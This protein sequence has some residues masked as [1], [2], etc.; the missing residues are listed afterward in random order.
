MCIEYIIIYTYLYIHYKYYKYIVNV[1]LYAAMYPCT[2]AHAV[3]CDSARA[4]CYLSLRTVKV[5]Y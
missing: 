2:R 3:M 5:G 4:H 1:S